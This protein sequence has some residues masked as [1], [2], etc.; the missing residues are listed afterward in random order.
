[1]SDET[2]LVGLLT[3]A[4]RLN[5]PHR[6]LAKECREGRLPCL[7]VSARIILVDVELPRGLLL[8]RARIMPETGE[9]SDQ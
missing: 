8:E 4:K 6:F 9:G 5:V 2:N 7:R 1:M 3:A